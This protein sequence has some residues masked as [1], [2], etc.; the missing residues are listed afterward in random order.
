MARTKRQ[1]ENRGMYNLNY[2]R[3]KEQKA[4]IQAQGL[5]KKQI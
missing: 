3:M 5:K 1:E 2:E 4:E